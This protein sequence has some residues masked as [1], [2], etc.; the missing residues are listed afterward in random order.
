MRSAKFV[1]IGA[2]FSRFGAMGCFRA[3]SFLLVFLAV[4]SIAAAQTKAGDKDEVI[5]IDTQ[6]VNVPIAVTSA[7]GTPVRGLT[8]SNFIVYENGVRQ[9]VADFSTT[10]APYEVA[11]LLDT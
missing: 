4:A 11:L 6:L 2:I 5:R 7:T 3:S 9:D 1:T 8:A 10:A